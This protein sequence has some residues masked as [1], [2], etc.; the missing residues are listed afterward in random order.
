V[1]GA[2]VFDL[3]GDKRNV[4]PFRLAIL[5]F[6]RIEDLLDEALDTAFGG[7]LPADLLHTH[8]RIRVA[9]ARALKLLPD[10]LVDPLGRLAKLRHAFAHGDLEHLSQSR[11]KE[12]W[13]S[14]RQVVPDLDA[15][16]PA[17]DELEPEIILISFLATLEVGLV[18]A[19]AEARERRER[20]EG[21]LRDWLKVWMVPLT[22][23]R[24]RELLASEAT[25]TQ[26]VEE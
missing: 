9:L 26:E 15:Q 5:G 4:D 14:L 25:G 10:E 20:D 12:L 17:F 2:S 19:F 11:A 23:E 18:G 24:I 1:E 21:V 3:F 13:S 8:F 16:L 22:E 7:E 6:A